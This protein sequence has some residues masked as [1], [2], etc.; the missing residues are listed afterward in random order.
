MRR[1]AESEPF[2]LFTIRS[3]SQPTNTYT[4]RRATCFE[5]ERIMLAPGWEQAHNKVRVA[6]S[7][8]SCRLGWI[9][10]NLPV[11]YNGEN[12]SCVSLSLI[13]YLKL[14]NHD[15][16]FWVSP[17]FHYSDL[18]LA[19]RPYRFSRRKNRKAARSNLT[20]DSPPIPRGISTKRRRFNSRVGQA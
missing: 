8:Y 15:E 6:I 16:I 5:P 2:T 1:V 7:G 19:S 9:P 12:S 17:A 4:P 20:W 3:F 14:C 18:V 13:S 10:K 11:Y